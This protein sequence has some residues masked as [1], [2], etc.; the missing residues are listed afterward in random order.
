MD[1]IHWTHLTLTDFH[2]VILIY[3]SIATI[4]FSGKVQRSFQLQVFST[5]GGGEDDVETILSLR[6]NSQIPRLPDARDCHITPI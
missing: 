1:A 5:S 2:F 6:K 4:H 3:I